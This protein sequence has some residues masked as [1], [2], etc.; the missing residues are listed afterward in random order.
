MGKDYSDIGLTTNLQ[1]QD[2]LAVR[3]DNEQ[4]D[5]FNLVSDITQNLNPQ[6]SQKTAF[7]ELFFKHAGTVNFETYYVAGQLTSNAAL[8]SSTFSANILRALPYVS[9][10]NG[11]VD[12]I[13]C[14]VTGTATSGE[15]RL[16]IY[17]ATSHSNLYPY[18]LILDTGTFSATTTGVRIGTI[19]IDLERNTLYW[20]VHV[21]SGVTPAYVNVNNDD[22]LNVLGIGTAFAEAATGIQIGYTYGT[23]Q[24]IFPSGGTITDVSLPAVGVRYLS[25]GAISQGERVGVSGG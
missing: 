16:G 11:R 21:S 22:A 3:R 13:T 7:T 17:Q 4:L 12:R 14:R 8:G 20:F 6:K 18:Q 25:V 2:S 5:I 15:F 23:L 1:S 24:T 19:D 9:T 10:V